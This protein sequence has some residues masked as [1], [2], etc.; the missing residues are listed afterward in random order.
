MEVPV[1]SRQEYTLLDIDDDDHMSLMDDKGETRE[2]LKL[3]DDRCGEAAMNLGIEVQKKF[4]E[5][6]ELVVT[7]L[8]AMGTDQLSAW[9]EATN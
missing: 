6:A 5:D 8:S 1:V 4:D 7:I 9:K 2:D 3:P